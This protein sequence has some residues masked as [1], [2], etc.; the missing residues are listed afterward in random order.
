MYHSFTQAKEL[1]A[2]SNNNEQSTIDHKNNYLEVATL[3]P[4]KYNEIMGIMEEQKL[5]NMIQFIKS[6]GILVNSIR[7]D[8]ISKLANS[9]E[10]RETT[11]G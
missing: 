10:I 6:T 9:C 1:I 11:W 7:E 2:C 3:N 4:S 5:N 8:K